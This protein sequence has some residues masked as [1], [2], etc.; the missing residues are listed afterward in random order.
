[1][2]L[3][4]VKKQSNKE[5]YNPDK[6]VQEL[7]D[8]LISLMEKGCNPFRKEWSPEAD[9]MNIT[10]GEYYQ[11]GNLI[12]LE[13]YKLAQGHKFPYWCGFKQA[14]KWGLK[15]KKGS[16]SAVILRPITIN[17]KRLDDDG[18]QIE[19]GARFTIFR[20]TRVFNIGCFVGS[21][22]ENQKK[23]DDR[24]A[25][26]EKQHAATNFEPLDDRLKNVHDIVVTNYIDKHLKNFSHKG[27]RAY[28]DV[29]FDEIVVPDRTR[30]SNN[31]NYYAVVMHEACHS[32][33]SQ[34]RLKRDGIVK[35]CGFGSELYAEE[36]IITECAAFLLARELKVSTTDDQHASYLK[37]W[38]SKLRKEPKFI[39]TILGQSVKAKNFILNPIVDKSDN[40]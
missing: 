22:P 15:I 1:M 30:F 9:H 2:T 37:N 27:D 11:N 18:Q 7:A 5:P 3:T 36:E 14:Q 20:P 24:I 26:L 10:T 35:A 12:A 4:T 38:I 33:G 16:K 28:Y 29:L 8:T 17:D 34:E 13:I 40:T 19:T 31:E 32:T 21:T 39:N 23:L 6:G 25:D